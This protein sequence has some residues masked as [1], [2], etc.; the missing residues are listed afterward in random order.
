MNND[1]AS[2]IAAFLADYA[3]RSL[4]EESNGEEA[5]PEILL[6]NAASILDDLYEEYLDARDA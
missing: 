4:I 5:A 6:A 2:R 3:D 1:T